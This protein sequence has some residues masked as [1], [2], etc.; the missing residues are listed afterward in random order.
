MY[1]DILINFQPMKLF[2]Y[3]CCFYLIVENHQLQRY[4]VGIFGM[5]P[6]TFLISF[7]FH[8]CPSFWAFCIS[9][10]KFCP[11]SSPFELIFHFLKLRQKIIEVTPILMLAMVPGV[12]FWH[13]SMHFFHD[14]LS[15]HLP[16]F[17]IFLHF[18]AEI[19]S[20]HSTL[21]IDFSFSETK[22]DQD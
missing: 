15:L 7:C 6:C 1:S 19:L 16:F 11:C 18:L 22:T 4:L 9:S 13:V 14:F 5:S 21:W 20:L 3:Y 12:H 17:F 2:V 10:M 8:T